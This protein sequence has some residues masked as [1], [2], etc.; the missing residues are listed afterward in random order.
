MTVNLSMLAGAGAQFFTS[1][2]VILSGGLVYTYAAGTTTP[3]A[4]YTTISGSTAHTNPIVLDSAGR[5]PSGGEIWLTDAVAYKFVLQTSVAVLIATYDNITGNSSGIY[6]TFAASSGSS[7]VGFIQ[8]GSGAVATTVQEKLRETVSSSDFGAVGNGTTN[9]TTALVNFFAACMAGKRGYLEAGTYSVDEGQII[10]QP[11]SNADVTG[12]YVETAGYFATVIKGRGTTQAPLITIQNLTQ[13]SGV[14]KFLKGGYLGDLGFNG[15]NQNSAWSTAHALSLRGLDGWE[16]GYLYG[17]SLKGDLLNIPP[18]LFGGNNPDPYH[19]A[20]CTFRGLQSNFGNGWVLNNENFVGFTSN[21]VFN[22]VCYG[23]STGA[24]AINT[25]GA[26]NLYKKISVGT[27]YGWAIKIYDG[28]TGGRASRETFSIAELDDPEYGIYIFN[29]DQAIFDQIRIVHRY[30]AGIGYW[31]REALKLSDVTNPSLT[32]TLIDITHRIEAG[33]VIADLGGFLRC[34]SSNAIEGVEIV[35]KIVD[36]ASF[37]ITN[38]N[39][40]SGALINSIASLR[41]LTNIQG[42]RTV[43]FDN[44]S[45]PIVYVTLNA[46]ASIP[47]GGFGGAG[48]NIAVTGELYDRR[49]NFDT[50]TYTYTAPVTGLYRVFASIS[51]TGVASGTTFRFGFRNSSSGDIVKYFTGATSSTGKFVFNGSGFVELTAGDQITLN[52]DNNSGGAVTI[53][54]V[55][56]LAAENSWSVELIESKR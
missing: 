17:V 25:C 12:F 53:N 16:F 48:N 47:N 28:A 8:A 33:G 54:T 10:I 46:G 24:G 31:P 15:A 23:S 14:G 44:Q 49:S 2:G 4:A 30:H 29:H 45:K 52:A 36:N 38:A 51:I 56:S 55:Y 41:L 18:N 39:I 43:A 5:V 27:C 22:V 37:G 7:L 3:Q 50:T 42:N 26:G 1:N 32:N 6:A 11:T 20:F 21:E 35:Y 34:Q 40:L 13:T 19:V 9:D